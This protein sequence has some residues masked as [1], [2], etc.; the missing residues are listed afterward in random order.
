M[1]RSSAATL[2][3]RRRVGELGDVRQSVDRLLA[4]ATR[5]TQSHPDQA[6]SMVLSETYFQRAKFAY[7]VDGEPV[8][9]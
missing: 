9:G 7:R 4:L 8:I 5:L 3:A 6:A 1:L 2:V